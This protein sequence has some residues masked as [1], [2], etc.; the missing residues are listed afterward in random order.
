MNLIQIDSILLIVGLFWITPRKYQ[1]FTII[2]TCIFYLVLEEEYWSLALLT[3]LSVTGFFVAN[4]KS[5]PK[6]ISGLIGIIVIFSMYK[7]LQAHESNSANSL[8]LLGTSYYCMRFIH[9]LIEGYKGSLPTH[10]FTQFLSYS[11][12]LPTFLVG[13]INRFQDFVRDDFRRRWDSKLFI[14]GIERIIFGYFKIVVLANY[15]VATKLHTYAQLQGGD[16]TAIGAYLLCLE[17]GLDLYF[18]FGGYSDI[19][20]GVSAMMGFRIIENFNYPFLKSNIN[21][22]WQSWHISLS[23]WCRD[24]VYSPVSS[25]LRN[26]VLGITVS[27]LIL[28]LWHEVSLRY[29]AWGLYH[30][31]GIV[32]FRYWQT[33]TFPGL[34]KGTLPKVITYPLATA[35][36]FNFVILSFA[37]TRADS[38][39][40]ALKIYLTIFAGIV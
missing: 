10:S 36:T 34:T 22:F 23:S 31:L 38:L 6:L 33:I 20:I 15:L 1:P 2:F 12:F 3:V 13:P 11:F 29:I 21:T 18:R 35:L 17:Y 24:Y 37:I 19:A 27:M 9:Y 7:L 5:R 39:K 4:Q 14:S 16:T 30:A 8:V 28:G 32:V 40:E 26:H 25:T